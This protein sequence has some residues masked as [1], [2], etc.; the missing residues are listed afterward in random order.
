VR[1][2]LPDPKAHYEFAVA[3]AH[4]KRTREAMS[5]YANALLIQPDFP[6]ALDGLAWI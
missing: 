1:G 6:D 5:Q 3:L 4:L 2:D